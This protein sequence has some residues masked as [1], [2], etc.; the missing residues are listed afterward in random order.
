MSATQY[1]FG[2]IASVVMGQ[3]PP[4]DT[5]NREM[6]GVP[7]LNGPAEFSNPYPIAVQWTTEPSRFAAPGDILFCVRGATTG[8]KC[9]SDQRY[10]VGRGLA[11]IRG[12]SGV[13]NTQ[14]LWFL[15]DVV[16]ESLLKR[17]AGSTFVNLPGEE[18]LNF[19]V[20]LPSLVEQERIAARLTAQHAAVERARTAALARRAAA[21]ALPAAYL[22]EIFE[23]P[24]AREWETLP[25]SEI[26]RIVEGQVDPREPQFGV[27]PHVNGEN[28]ESGTGRILKV[29]TA[30]EDGLISGKYLFESGYAPGRSRH[31]R[32]E[33]AAQSEAAVRRI[34]PLSLRALP[35]L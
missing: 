26:C 17:A 1:R 11:A 32:A 15:L 27:L 3:S 14:Y 2:D 24:E 31:R 30:T 8:R 12:R 19:R 34:A 22:R 16:I 33:P 21:E 20:A 23:G 35:R 9:W 5:Y 6:R 4:G 28:I 7:L 10:A 13:C 18:I 29:R 25:M